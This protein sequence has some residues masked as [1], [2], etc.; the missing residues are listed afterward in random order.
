[1]QI[2]LWL[3]VSSRIVTRL[4]ANPLSTNDKRI[5]ITWLIRVNTGD[6]RKISTEW[7]NCA[8][9]TYTIELIQRQNN[10]HYLLIVIISICSKTI[11]I[12]YKQIIAALKHHQYPIIIYI[13]TSNYNINNIS[14]MY[15][16]VTKLSC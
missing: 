1:M 6:L 11:L 3:G 9:I 2:S 10:F 12:K 14:T 7:L 15:T 13:G 8:V 5:A 16:E 4:S